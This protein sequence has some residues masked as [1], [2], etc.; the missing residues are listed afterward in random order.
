MIRQSDVTRAVRA[1]IMGYRAQH[2]GIGPVKLSVEIRNGGLSVLIEP[3]AES[4]AP[5]PQGGPTVEEL[6][7]TIR[8]KARAARR[9]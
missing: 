9:A 6:A 3:S 5:A 8:T 2:P 4:P 1:A 7:A